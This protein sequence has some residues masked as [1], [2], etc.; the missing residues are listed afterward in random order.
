MAGG[1]GFTPRRPDSFCVTDAPPNSLTM[2]QTR[3]IGNSRPRWPPMPG[4]HGLMIATAISPSV[5]TMRLSITTTLY[6]A[7]KISMLTVLGLTPTNTAGFGGRTPAQSIAIPTGRRIVTVAGCGFHL[8]AGPGSAMNPGV[9][10]LI[11]MAAG[12]TTTTT[13]PGARAASSTGIAAGG[14][15][16]S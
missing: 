15:R 16:R 11:T 6:G 9:G 2:D 14:D 7:R 3:A 1:R 10:R 8:M 13:G 12:F 5:C 4:T